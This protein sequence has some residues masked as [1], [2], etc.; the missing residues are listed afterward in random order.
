[1]RSAFVAHLAAVREMTVVQL[2]TL[3]KCKTRHIRGTLL[4]K[5]IASNI[6]DFL[7]TRAYPLQANHAYYHEGRAPKKFT[8]LFSFKKDLEYGSRAVDPVSGRRRSHWS[9]THVTGDKSNVRQ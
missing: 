4:Y 1:M 6:R 9:A 3:P 7:G 5:S 2:S 8:P